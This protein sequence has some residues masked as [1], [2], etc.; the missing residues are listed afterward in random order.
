MNKG[1]AFF[2]KYIYKFDITN[3]KDPIMMISAIIGKLFFTN[4]IF[5]K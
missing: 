5:A 2:V 1:Y 4:G 3:T